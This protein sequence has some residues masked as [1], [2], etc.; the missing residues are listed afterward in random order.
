MRDFQ[1]PDSSKSAPPAARRRA[2]PVGAST[3]RKG[4]SFWV[5]RH[6]AAPTR[7]DGPSRVSASGLA[8]GERTD[9]YELEADRAADRVTGTAHV[10]GALADREAGPV[11]DRARLPGGELLDPETRRYFEPRLGH[12]FADVRVHTDRAADLSVRGLGTS[13]YTVG[14]DIAFAEGTY[15]PHDSRGRRLLAHELAHV[16]QQTAAPA[17]GR[18]YGSAGTLAR[19]P[20]P[21]VQRDFTATGDTA[22]FAR[23]VNGIL[24]VQHEIRI[25]AAGA[26]TIHATQIQGPPTLE[27]QE[28]LATVR[29]VV[30]DPRTTTI[31]FIRGTTSARASDRSVIV[32]SYALSRVDLDDVE[33]FGHAGPGDTAAIQLVH[34]ITEQY[35]KQAHGEGFPVAHRAGY[36]AQERALGATLVAESPMTP[37]GGSLGEV[38][39]TYRYPDGRIV[40]VITRMDFA[41]GN[42]VSVR[43]VVR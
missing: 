36:A 16:V 40:D 26:V 17:S 28:L 43:R 4:W 8:V 27:A 41:T 9:H 20:S 13:A 1:H 38:T 24:A 14:R 23:L 33:A 37:I 32:G 19:V 18:S 30:D 35:R 6:V 11:P 34:E 39:T 5:F 12:S 3:S 21:R 15:A 2:D 7:P 22:G 25:S 29:R 31:E 10:G 42:I